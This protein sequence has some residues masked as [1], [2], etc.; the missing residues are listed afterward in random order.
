MKICLFDHHNNPYPIQGYGGIERSNQ[1]LFQALSENDYDVTLICVE[2]S[3]INFNK[4]NSKVITLP[5]EELENIRYGRTPVCRYFNGD[6]FQTH[7]SSTK[8][9]NFDFE[10]FC[11][12]WVATC[13][14]YQEWAGA[15]YQTFLTNNQCE[16]HIRDG[17]I[18]NTVEYVFIT[19]T[20]VNDSVLKYVNGNHDKIVWL[21]RICSDKGID[22]LIQIAER[23]NETIL[24]AG[25]IVD[26]LLFEK[27]MKIKN[28][29]YYGVIKTEQEKV[30]FFSNA[31]LSLHT[32]IF[33]EPLGLTILEAQMCGIPVTTWANGSV[34][35]TNYDSSN[36]HDNLDDIVNYIQNKEYLKYSNVEIENWT[37]NNFGK[38]NILHTFTE[39][40]N[41]VIKN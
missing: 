36:V 38:L 35:E 25:N 34:I 22:R 6:V 3:T 19:N 15:K 10:G 23:L 4:N 37:K 39:V 20:G 17:L 12:K 32:S 8:H 16:Q 11:G 14:G 5:F 33:E 24:V 40:Y 7:T 26:G 29:E 9:C 21:A 31:K 13:Q 41:F 30:N 27:L 2:G 18:E 1:L 28:V